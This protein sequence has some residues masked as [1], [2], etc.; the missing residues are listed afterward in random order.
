M[1]RSA[2]AAAAGLAQRL[3]HAERELR[4]PLLQGAGT[5]PSSM[6]LPI[7]LTMDPRSPSAAASSS[8]RGA[9]SSEATSASAR[10]LQQPLLVAERGS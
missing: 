3:P 10:R 2:G 9:S 6:L 7:A 8:S 4:A 5:A 1:E